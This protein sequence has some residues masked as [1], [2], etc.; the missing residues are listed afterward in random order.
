MSG[1]HLGRTSSHRIAMRRNLAASLIEHGAI[2]TTEA[3]AK[4]ARRF[5][6]RLITTAKKDTLHARRQVLAKLGRDRIILNDEGEPEEKTLVQRLFDEIAP[7]YAD[8]PGGYTR[9]IRIAER[10]IGD[11]GRQVI[12]QLV[13]EEVAGAKEEGRRLSRRRRRATKRHEAAGTRPEGDAAD[14]AE[15][16]DVEETPPGEEGESEAP[17][18]PE[19]AEAGAP[20]A[21]DAGPAADEGKPQ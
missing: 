6:E 14:A 7:R 2:R 21:A 15:E 17:E 8:R 9:I 11:A 5:I 19:E 4:D 13:E 16:Q 3:K 10:R 20:E 12:L 1:K 18:Q